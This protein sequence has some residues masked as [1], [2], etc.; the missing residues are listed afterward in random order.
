MF[1]RFL[2]HRKNHNTGE[3]ELA[4]PVKLI[5]K[6]DATPTKAAGSNVVSV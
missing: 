5:H 1:L 4:V 2:L 6:I 3:K